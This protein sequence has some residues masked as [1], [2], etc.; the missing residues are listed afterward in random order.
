MNSI[1]PFCPQ[2]ND[3]VVAIPESR[4]IE[5]DVEQLLNAICSSR[6][7]ATMITP[8]LARELLL[9]LLLIETPVIPSCFFPG[10]AAMPAPDLSGIPTV[11][12]ITPDALL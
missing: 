10:K 12:T 9:K 8:Q 3:A 2:E 4:A 5:H 11:T 7:Y 6:P 1:V